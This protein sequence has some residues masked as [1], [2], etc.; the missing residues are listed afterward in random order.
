M[1]TLLKKQYKKEQ[2]CIIE[3]SCSIPWT[4]QQDF[5]MY[6]SLASEPASPNIRQMMNYVN[7]F[8]LIVK[9]DD[10]I[11]TSNHNK[12]ILLFFFPIYKN[13]WKEYKF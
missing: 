6:F 13:E 2:F 11:N 10:S 9:Y 5:E 7:V 4:S 3:V 8:S 1:L 12:K